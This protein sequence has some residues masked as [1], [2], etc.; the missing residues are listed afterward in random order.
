ML[1]FDF[2]SLFVFFLLTGM[3]IGQALPFDSLSSLFERENAMSEAKTDK[4]DSVSLLPISALA[5]D[6]WPVISGQSYSCRLG[7]HFAA[8]YAI[9]LIGHTSRGP[10]LST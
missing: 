5:P 2:R 7:E 10:P 6:L 8:A 4:P 1:K 3:F 9:F